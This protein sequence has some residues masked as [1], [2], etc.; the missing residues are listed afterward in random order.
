MGARV[1]PERHSRE[2][3][4]PEE[5]DPRLRGGDDGF[6]RELED[7]RAKG[8]ARTLRMSD[9]GVFNLSSNDY[10]GLSTHPSV[11]GG[12]RAALERL[13]TGGTS[14]RL[15][16]GTSDLHTSL[17]NRIADFLGKDA[18]IVFSSGYHANTGIL[19]ALL[20]PSDL[21]VFDRLC[22][23]SIIDGVRLSGAAYAPFAHNDTADLN[24]VLSRKRKGRRRAVVVTEGF[25]SM[26]GDRPPLAEI[27]GAA[28]LH[29]ALVYLDEAH[30]IGVT[31][32]NGKGVAWEDK[33]SD[34][35][36]LHVGTLSKALA[37]QG[38]F[39]AAR[40]TIIDLLVTRCRSF[41]FTTALAPACA[42][43]SLAALDLLP[44][45]TDRRDRVMGD[46]DE[47][48]LGLKKLGY[49]TLASVSPIV[50]VW[51]G[52]VVS[53]QKLSGHLLK[54][55]FFV[56]SIRPPTVSPGEG[57]VRLSIT[58]REDRRWLKELLAAFESYGERPHREGD[59]IV[60]AG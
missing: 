19:P 12:A 23:A 36:D 31:G 53:T 34:R 5:M 17:E 6:D 18:A 41:L 35:I 38:G 40:R 43:A 25:F 60:Q 24:K 11:V 45:L 7:L 30:S 9:D 20:G 22:H 56:P 2:S 14:S 49:D 3:G 16:A 1:S 26:D 21:V 59:R 46:A 42:G 33:L 39:V 37:S 27:A 15:L 55:G 44:S 8:L 54:K 10:L 32:P 29:D 48:R 47:L 13:G 58:Y 52:S 57:R 50:P 28:R 51:T 4:N